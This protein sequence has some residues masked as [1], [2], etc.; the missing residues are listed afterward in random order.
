MPT[1]RRHQV[2]LVSVRCVSSE[3]DFAARLV[4]AVERSRL[5]R[6]KVIEGEVISA[7]AHPPRI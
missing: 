5:A 7:S 1:S 3:G 4:R 2:I 6:T